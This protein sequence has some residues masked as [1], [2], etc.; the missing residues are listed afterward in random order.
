MTN[1]DA[2]TLMHPA[3]AKAILVAAVGEDQVAAWSDNFKRQGASLAEVQ[4][5]AMH[6][7][8]LSPKSF[9]N[10]ETDVTSAIV[11]SISAGFSPLELPRSVAHALESHTLHVVLGARLARLGAIMSA[12]PGGASQ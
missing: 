1:P 8:G 2:D 7:S 11:A 5:L 6:G 12:P 3:A 4:V 10:L 9:D